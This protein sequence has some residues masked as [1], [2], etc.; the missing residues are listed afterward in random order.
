MSVDAKP[1]RITFVPLLVTPAENASAS[2]GDEG[3]ISSP[4]ITVLG[5]RSIS[6]NLAKAKPTAKAKS[7]ATLTKLRV[8]LG[9]ARN[10]GM[11]LK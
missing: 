10:A 8:A 3:R 9:T 6:R 4:M 2:S 7:L 5:S 1:M 11:T